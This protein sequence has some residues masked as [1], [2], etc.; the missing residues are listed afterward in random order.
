MRDARSM[1]GITQYVQRVSRQS[2]VWVEGATGWLR[3]FFCV[4]AARVVHRAALV[5]GGRSY[6]S[7]PPSL[8]HWN[9]LCGGVSAWG[10]L[11]RAFRGRRAIWPSNPNAIYSMRLPRNVGGA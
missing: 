11:R 2:C 5:G 4:A 6:A 10:D 9:G 3:V 8:A 1:M 7:R